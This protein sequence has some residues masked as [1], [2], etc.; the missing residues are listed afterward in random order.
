MLLDDRD[1]ARS[2]LGQGLLEPVQRRAELALEG[3]D[4]FARVLRL[5]RAA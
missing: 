4:E 3:G 5:P 1:P 2:A